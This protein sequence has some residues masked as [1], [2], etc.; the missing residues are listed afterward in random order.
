MAEGTYESECQ[1]AE[2]L[3]IEPPKFEDWQEAERVRLEQLKS[4]E[5]EVSLKL[6]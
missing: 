4:A 3:G 2:L 1:R 6:I 5:A